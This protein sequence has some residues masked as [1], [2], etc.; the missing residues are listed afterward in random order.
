MFDSGVI[1]EGE[2]RCQSLLEVKESILKQSL[3]NCVLVYTSCEV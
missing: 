2:G 1:L 3:P